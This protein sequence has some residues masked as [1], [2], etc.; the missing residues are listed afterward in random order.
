MIFLHY[1]N[2]NT[3]NKIKKLL[4]FSEFDF[5]FLYLQDLPLTAIKRRKYGIQTEI[6]HLEV[7]ICKDFVENI[8][9]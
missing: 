3:F 1:V 5:L 2:F 8:L 6:L 9:F 4:H 7:V